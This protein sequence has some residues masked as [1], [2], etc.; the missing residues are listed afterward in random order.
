MVR[1][2]VNIL[3]RFRFESGISSG[4]GRYRGYRWRRARA[5]RLWRRSPSSGRGPFSNDEVVAGRIREAGARAGRQALP[6][7]APADARRSRARRRPG[8]G[9]VLARA[10]RAGKVRPARAIRH[11]PMAAADHAQ[12]ARQPRRARTA[13]AGRG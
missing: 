4:L 11:A 8:A 9:T 7:R 10:P 2:E 1:L 12:P 3:M 6:T 5:E 13:P